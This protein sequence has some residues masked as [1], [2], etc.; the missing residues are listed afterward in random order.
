[1]SAPIKLKEKIHPSKKQLVPISERRPEN[2]EQAI[3]Q[4]LKKFKTIEG[5]QK[6]ELILELKKFYKKNIPQLIDRRGYSTFY[7]PSLYEFMSNS[8]ILI[9]P[10]RKIKKKPEMSLKRL[11]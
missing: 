9:H 1:M 2:Y 4:I 10:R 6:E 11:S 3:F 5:I 8:P 7:I